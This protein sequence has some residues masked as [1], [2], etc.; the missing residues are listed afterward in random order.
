MC[1]IWSQG[2]SLFL[3]PNPIFK[4]EKGFLLCDVPE[5]KRLKACGSALT[6]MADW[7]IDSGP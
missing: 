3:R 2:Q 6:R 5:L 1:S 7:A 4:K